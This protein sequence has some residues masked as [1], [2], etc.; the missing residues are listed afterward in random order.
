[1]AENLQGYKKWIYSGRKNTLPNRTL[2]L[3]K[4]IKRTKSLINKGNI[5]IFVLVILQYNF[6][7]KAK[8]VAVYFMFLAYVKVK[9][10][11]SI[12]QTIDS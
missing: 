9:G 10:I 6:V 4:E 1:M 8:I 3:Y 12:A 2:D 7:L 11:K 5:Y